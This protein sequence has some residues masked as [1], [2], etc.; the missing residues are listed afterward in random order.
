MQ[1]DFE[2]QSYALESKNK[3][4]PTLPAQ[5]Q[6]STPAPP[7]FFPKLFNYAELHAMKR[8]VGQVETE[9]IY[10]SRVRA[11]ILKIAEEPLSDA[12]KTGFESTD[13]DS[14]TASIHFVE[15]SL[16]RIA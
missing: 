15:Q 3:D 5:E 12:F 2:T 11:S 6:H 16:I 8:K 13:E 9:R 7:I 1:D 10:A 4:S 14:K